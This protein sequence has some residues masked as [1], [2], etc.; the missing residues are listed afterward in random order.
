MTECKHCE[1]LCHEP[2]TNYNCDC[3]VVQKIPKRP[4]EQ[5]RERADEFAKDAIKDTNFTDG[6]AAAAIAAC[7]F[8]ATLEYL[9]AQA[10]FTQDK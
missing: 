10:G 6:E 2:G 1:C 8:R 9:D 4:S 5:I 3:C 7:Y